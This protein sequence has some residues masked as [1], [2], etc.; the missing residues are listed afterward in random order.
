MAARTK[1][2]SQRRPAKP[3]QPAQKAKPGNPT[4]F[5]QE[6]ADAIC[7]LL[8]AGKSLRAICSHE[9]MPAQSTVHLWLS[10]HKEFSEQYARAREVQ[11]DVLVDQIIAI[12]DDGSADW[13][14]RE[15]EDGSTYTVIEHEHVNRSKLRVEARKWAASKMAPKKYGDRIEHAIGDPDGKPIGPLFNISG[16][17]SGN[18]LPSEAGDRVRKS[19]H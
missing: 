10:R 19:S 3:A 11:A 15:R 5:T 1:R 18:S 14:E 6:T 7:R 4:T 8:M 16:L 2:K 12:A 9:G 13:V 17:T